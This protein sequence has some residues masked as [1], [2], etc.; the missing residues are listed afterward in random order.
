MDATQIQKLIL[1]VLSSKDSR[2]GPFIA[3]SLSSEIV[4]QIFPLQDIQ[5]LEN[6]WTRL[7]D[8][9]CT[10]ARGQPMPVALTLRFT[11]TWRST[12]ISGGTGTILETLGEA[13]SRSSIGL[14]LTRYKFKIQN[15]CYCRFILWTS[16]R[17]NNKMDLPETLNYKL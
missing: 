11:R 8:Q 15:S 13:S 3:S 14:Q 12:V 5:S 7:A 1:K 6:I 17:Q 2:Q 4:F 10:H 16:Y 9:S